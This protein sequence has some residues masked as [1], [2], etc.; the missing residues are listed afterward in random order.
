MPTTTEWRKICAEAGRKPE[1]EAEARAALSQVLFNDYPTY[2]R[3]RIAA[4]VERAERMLEQLA[5]FEAD[6]RVQFPSGVWKTDQD[7]EIKRHIANRNE[8]G[9]RWLEDLRGRTATVLDEARRQQRANARRRNTRQEMLYH[10]LCGVWL[11]Y[12]E[13]PELPPPGSARTPL[14]NFVLAAMR[15]VVP[16][17]ELPKPDTVRDNIERE[18]LARERSRRIAER[19][20]LRRE[21][22]GG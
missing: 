2:D 19:V 18:R 8:R 10:S 6:Y 17:R 20:R 21:R 16:R 11:D 9:L 4:I 1:T 7:Y 15:L 22:S 12:F 3:E 5:A 14:V 13:G